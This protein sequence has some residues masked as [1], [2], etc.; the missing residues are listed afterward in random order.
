[1]GGS[2]TGPPDA[3]AGWL[4]ITRFVIHEEDSHVSA[5]ASGDETTHETELAKGN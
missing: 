3:E 4:E 2:R 1:M 5:H